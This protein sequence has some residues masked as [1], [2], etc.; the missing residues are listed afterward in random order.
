MKLKYTARTKQGELQTGFIEAV[1][2]EAAVSVLLGHE[3]FVLTIES[4]ET[5]NWFD[6]FLNLVNRVKTGDLMVF[7]RQFA[8]LLDAK[9]SLG[10]SLKNLYK[11]TGNVILKEIISE[12]SNDIDS[13]LLLSQAMER[14]SNVFSNFYVSMIRSAEVTGRLEEAMGFMAD[15]LEKEAALMAKVRSALIYPV[16]VL[17]LFMVVA[18]IMVGFVFPQ[19]API[20]EESS[21]EIPFITQVLL[22]GGKFIGDQWLA[23]VIIFL[24]S[25]YVLYDYLKTPEGKA[26]FAEVSIVLPVVGDLYKKLYGA[27]FT[28]AT[29]VLIR[30][31]VPISQ[32]LE[33]SGHTIDSVIY[34]DALHEIAD[35]VR[36]GQLMSQALS[37]RE[38]YFPPLVS[39]MVAVGESTG[40]LES[41]LSRISNFYTREVDNVVSNLV[42]LIQPAMMI[43]IGVLVALLFA[44]VLLPI[45]N[46]VNSF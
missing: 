26:V 39:Q 18:G 30:G 37:E 22:S 5:S 4:A 28:E 8:T 3:L 40:K 41:L 16:I 14:H 32:S 35:A 33:I 15:Y 17:V 24:I 29:A 44:A 23:I 25:G 31:G 6:S 2:R 27:R 38:E 19:L 36:G 45:Y 20:F 12:I 42:D 11:Q 21:A 10:D 13:G 7:T 9:I 34:R 43:G 1:S 46:L